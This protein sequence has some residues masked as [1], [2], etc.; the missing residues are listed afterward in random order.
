M[1][2][3]CVV[4]NGECYTAW[5]VRKQVMKNSAEAATAELD[6]VTAGANIAS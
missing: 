1:L 2:R 4:V 3:T 5:N 6:V